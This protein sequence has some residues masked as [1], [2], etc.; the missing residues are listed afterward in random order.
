MTA[1]DFTL[2]HDKVGTWSVRPASPDGYRTFRTIMSILIGMGADLGR[3]SEV[4]DVFV[5]ESS[6]LAN[7][8]A[9]A[10]ETGGFMVEQGSGR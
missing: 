4:G 7:D 6:A 8:I 10:L 5:I 1:F 9:A 2:T 3:I